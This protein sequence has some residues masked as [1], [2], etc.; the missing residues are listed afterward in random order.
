MHDQPTR[1]LRRA[2]AF[3]TLLGCASPLYALAAEQPARFD[4]PAQP[5]DGALTRFA[6]QAGL[7]ILF[8]SDDVAGLDGNA[9][10]GDYPPSQAL[11]RLLQGSGYGFQFVD[12]KTL[13]LRKL[14]QGSEPVE[15]DATRVTGRA[16][17]YAE[18]AYGPVDGIV[19]RRSGTGTKTDAAL[20]EIPQ[21]INVITRDEITLRGAKS[22]TEAL[23]YTPGMTFGGFSD[24]VKIFDEPTSR[25]FSPAPLYLDGLHLPYGGGSTGGALQIDPYL[26]ERI[27]VLKGPASVLY[28]QNQPGGIVNMASK[29]PTATPLREIVIGG[30]SWD[31]KYGAFDF[32][33]PLDEQGRFLYRLTGV[34][35]DSGSQIDYA[36]QNRM[37]LAPSLTW[38]P[39]DRTTLTLFAQY[40]K[41]RDTPEAQGLPAYGTVFSTTNGRISRSLYI[42]EPDLNAYDREQFVVGYE[43]VHELNNIWT[44]KQNARYAYV[45]DRYVAP[46]HGYSFPTNPVTGLNDRSYQTRFG[47]DWSQTNKVFGIDNIAQAKFKTGELDHTLL[48]GVDYY[49]FNSK[50]LGL[51]DRS[52]PA[53]DLYNPVYGSTFSFT[54]PYRWDNTI[55]Q[56]GLYVQDQLR[57]NHWI[58]TLGGRYDFAETDNKVPLSGTHANIEDEKLTVRAGLAYQFGNG[59]TP[60]LSYAESFLPQTGTNVAGSPF[61]P[62]AGEQYEVGVKYEPRGID[63]FIQLSMYQIDQLNMLTDDLANP[64]FSTQSGAVRSRGVE[65][66]GKLNVTQNLRALAAVSR[67]QSKWRSVND[68]REDRNMAKIAPLTASTWIDYTFDATPLAGLGAG[69]GVRYVRS[70]YGSD[71][72]PSSFQIP[73]YTVY[74]AMLRYDLEKSPLQLKGLAVKLNLENIA[75]KKYVA[76]CGGTLDCYYGA[77]RTLTADITYNW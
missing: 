43:V 29:R 56:T 64:G 5:L 4:I 30:G 8:T 31:R 34:V 15:L 57:W 36:D 38:L 17:H 52:G 35:N 27:E 19:A 23:R 20:S 77:S 11:Q 62:T 48:L 72:Q 68:G 44:L 55:R 54:S 7:R 26:L 32:G 6:D 58:L 33:G 67:N 42:G 9:L 60:Y 61:E 1:S 45:D 75:D 71:Y 74:D 21:T 69:M 51:Y 65:L 50:F 25:G 24:R 14:A 66:E 70:S 13:T 53:I 12:E 63:G 10:N 76:N 16:A 59:M 18:S 22:V 37:T 46:L 2:I 39:N 47:V 73:S 41:D 3:A 40:Q 49:H 28:G